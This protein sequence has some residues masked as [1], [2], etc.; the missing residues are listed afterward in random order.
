[1]ES[2]WWIKRHWCENGSPKVKSNPPGGNDMR[3]AHR[4]V[5]ETFT[6]YSRLPDLLN[7]SVSLLTFYDIDRS[8]VRMWVSWIP[9]R[10][11]R[12]RLEEML[13]H[14]SVARKVRQLADI[15]LVVVFEF[16][17]GSALLAYPILLLRRK[18][19]LIF[20]MWDQQ[21]ATQ[22]W[23]RYFCLLVFRAYLM[24][25]RALV[26]QTEIPD[27]C[28]P[29]RYRLPNQKTLVLPL[30]SQSRLSPG[31]QLGERRC[32]DEPIRIG[33]VGTPRRDKP[34]LEQEFL[35]HVVD[36]VR[37]IPNAILVIGCPKELLFPDLMLPKDVA[38]TFRDT[39]EKGAYYSLLRELD[40]LVTNYSKAGFYYRSS[41]V[42]MDAANCG[43][44]VVCPDYPVL[45]HQVEWPCP[46]GVVY[47]EMAR[48][49]TAIAEAAS[50]ARQ[51]GCDPH[52]DWIAGR[53]VERIAP[54]IQTVLTARFP[55]SSCSC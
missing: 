47:S 30:P 25:A 10:V 26:V 2:G 34:L 23:L 18:P 4:F 41:G 33:I 38:C 22:S 55:G 53:A 8:S 36:S 17:V 12:R 14:V 6:D 52:W 48:L 37:S 29:S 51:R 42:V 21:F 15:D 50:L 16:F 1:V 5:H 20:L 44:W 43:A 46:V 24:F 49:P 40:V 28:L 39:T 54:L 11:L 35:N 31:R 32:A 27:T 19:S 13:F 45:R 9:N 7:C 3:F